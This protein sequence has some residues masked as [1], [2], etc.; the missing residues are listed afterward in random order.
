ME[1]LRQW[2]R[3]ERRKLRTL[4]RRAKIE[5]IW[6][7]YKLWIIALV[8]IVG[9]TVYITVHRLTVPADNWLYVT[10][11][12]T[13][14]PVGNG[15]ELWRGFVD[16]SG[17]DTR[18]KNVYFNNSCYFD[19]S[20]TRYNPY[21]TYFVAYVEAGTLDAIAMERDDLET[22]GRRGRLLDLSLPAADGLA[23]KYADR[24]LYALPADSEYS[25]DP[26]PIGFDL[27]DTRLVTEFGAYQDSCALGISANC[28]H[29]DAV[30]RFL[31]YVLEGG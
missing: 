23:E 26:V 14:A 4:S 6:Q 1:T 12:N 25:S 21:Y 9:L 19:P 30:E 7:Y 8:S 5:Y 28:P 13:Y 2:F 29:I 22:L 31:E 27:S 11:A 3:T 17:Y 18:E 15:S 24:L 16:A 20:D 10:F